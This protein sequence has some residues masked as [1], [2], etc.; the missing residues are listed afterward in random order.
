MQ[1]FKDLTKLPE[2]SIALGFFDGLHKGH[3]AVIKNTVDFAKQNNI[4]SAVITFQDHPC[5]FFYST[6]PK[7][8]LTKDEKREKIAELGID[9]LFELDF[10]S[11]SGLKAEEYLKDILV[12]YFTPKAITTGWNHNFG[13]KQSGNVKFLALNAE[14]YDYKYFEIPP[15]KEGIKNISSTTIRDYLFDGLIEDAN[16]MLGYKFYI[17]GKVIEGQKLGR[18]IGFRTANIIYPQEL[19]ELPFGVYSVDVDIDGLNYKGITNFGIRPTVSESKICSLETHILNFDN[20]IYGKT[21]TIEFN[22]MIREEKKFSSVE[23]LKK[24]IKK[25]IQNLYE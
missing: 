2:L 17:K 16:K 15:Q 24:Q 6:N 12:K 9:Y 18:T 10:G 21:I 7:Y 11:I 3:N 14:K 19:V 1:I 22:K 4:K 23:E 25:D 20:D 8:I 5:C 13:Y